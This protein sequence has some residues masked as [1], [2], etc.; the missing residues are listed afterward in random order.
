MSRPRARSSVSG[1]RHSLTRRSAE[2]PS[3][4]A[5]NSKASPKDRRPSRLSMTGIAAAGT[6]PG[7]RRPTPTVSLARPPPAGGGAAL[8]QPPG[9]REGKD[10]GEQLLWTPQRMEQVLRGKDTLD[11]R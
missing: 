4:A 8:D 5:A 7:N 11:V 9:R 1:R 6:G 10:G 3:T 2:P